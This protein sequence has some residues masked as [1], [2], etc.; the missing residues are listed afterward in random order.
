MIAQ[1]LFDEL[2]QCA[3][4]AIAAAAD[5]ANVSDDDVIQFVKTERMRQIK[6]W[7]DQHHHPMKWLA[8]L[9]EEYGESCKASLEE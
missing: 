5:I 1:E 6:K 7:G 4:V 2:V 8:I 9:G 3:A